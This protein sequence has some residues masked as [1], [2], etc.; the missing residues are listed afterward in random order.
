MMQCKD[1]DDDPSDMDS[2]TG[3]GANDS[4]TAS[5]STQDSDTDHGI[6]S[7]S[8][9]NDSATVDETPTENEG[10]ESGTGDTE[11]QLALMLDDFEDGDN[12]SLLGGDWYWYTDENNNGAST[13]TVSQ[14]E[15][16]EMVMDAAGYESTTALM[17]SWALDKGDYEYDPYVGWGVNCGDE[18]TPFDISGYGG[19]TYMYKGDIHAVIIETT[20]I[21]DSDFYKLVVAASAEWRRIDIP[22]VLLAQEGWGAPAVFTPE[23]VKA[24][25]FQAKGTTGNTGTL[26]IDNLGFLSNQGL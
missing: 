3:S 22:Y 6:S 16:D 10:T 19:I 2:D 7:D 17:A 13:L 15:E 14:N 12:L 26:T 23:S 24:I 9:P 1:D 18:T 4:A 25:S 20:N 8:T 11:L 5:D 21:I